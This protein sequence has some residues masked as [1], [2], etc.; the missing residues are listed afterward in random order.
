MFLLGILELWVAIPAGFLLQLNPFFTALASSLGAITSVI[1]ILFI[2]EK[3]RDKLSEKYYNKEPGRRTRLLQS[4]WEKYGVIG[5]GLLSPLLFG[6]PLG[7]AI[8]VALGSDRSKLILWMSIG[9]II[10]SVGLTLAAIQGLNIYEM[11][12]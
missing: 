7:A 3:I 12:S 4:V 6:A 5:L 8:G 2:G 10:W 11:T 9:I 1:V